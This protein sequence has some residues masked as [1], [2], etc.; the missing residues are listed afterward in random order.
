MGTVD[1]QTFSG[2]S[3]DVGLKSG[4][5]IGHSTTFTE[6]SQSLSCSDLAVCLGSLSCW[7]VNLRP[8]LRSWVFWTRL[9]LR[10]S[11]TPFHSAFPQPW[12]VAAILVR[13]RLACKQTQVNDGAAVFLDKK[14]Y[15]VYDTQP[16]SL[17]RFHIQGFMIYVEY[18][19]K[20]CLHVT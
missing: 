9:S 18:Q 6:L 10:I 12:P 11:C 1:G 16:I 3:R 19:K 4:L 17:S 7:K 20:F 2:F 13:W 15:R 8:S 5:W 14:H